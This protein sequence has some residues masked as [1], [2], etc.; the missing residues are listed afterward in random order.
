M[1]GAITARS[2][3][4]EK[5]LTGAVSND[6]LGVEKWFTDLPKARIAME[7]GTHSIW[8]SEQLQ[9]DGPRGDRGEREGA[10]GDLAQ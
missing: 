2:T 1:S 9:G 6:T 4:M 8:V 3:K 5:W 10:A 7:A